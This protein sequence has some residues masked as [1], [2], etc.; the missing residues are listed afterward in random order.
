MMSN[1]EGCS[2]YSRHNGFA[3]DKPDNWQQRSL[4]DALPLVQYI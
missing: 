2:C 4:S 3:R 1:R